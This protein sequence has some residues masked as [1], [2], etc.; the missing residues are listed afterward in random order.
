M[1]EQRRLVA[2]L[3]ARGVSERL[4]CRT[5]GLGRSTYRYRARGR[6]TGEDRLRGLVVELARRRSTAVIRR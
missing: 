6:R 5:V 4:A 2:E 3:V 1:T